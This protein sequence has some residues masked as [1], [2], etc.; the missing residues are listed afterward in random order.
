MNISD[1]IEPDS[2]VLCENE[3]VPMQEEE[4]QR[5]LLLSRTL[6]AFLTEMQL[7][8]VKLPGVLRSDQGVPLSPWYNVCFKL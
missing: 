2:A 6:F 1:Y 5:A 7:L 8:K 3:C 4:E